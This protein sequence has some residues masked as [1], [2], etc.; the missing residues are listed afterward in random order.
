MHEIAGPA[1]LV[2]LESTAFAAAMRQWLWLYPIVEIVHI[3]GIALLVGSIAMFD[4]RIL[5]LSRALPVRGLARHLLPWTL[6]GFAIVAASGAMMFTAHATEFWSNPA[7]A[8]KLALI[9]LAG[10]N[11]LAFHLGPYA[12]VD[13][14]D[15]AAAAPAPAKAA[16]ALSLLLWLG[17]IACGRLLAYL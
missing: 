9:G 10:A 12:A 7:F 1:A 3:T 17:T 6:T 15:T 5:G 2:W 11:A 14:W 13:R 8:V 16:A 4:L